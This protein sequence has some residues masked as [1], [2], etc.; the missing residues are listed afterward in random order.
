MK[1]YKIWKRGEIV[2]SPHPGLYVGVKTTKVFGRLT[3]KS[4]AR[5]EN[6]I[7]FH[8]WDDAINAGYRA[9]KG[10]RP[11]RRIEAE[12]QLQELLKS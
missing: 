10:C 6:F 2:K 9:C 8:G 3:H 5:K 12:E 11:V 1:L 4:G 7:F